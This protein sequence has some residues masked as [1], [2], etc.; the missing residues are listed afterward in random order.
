M[1]TDPLLTHPGFPAALAAAAARARAT[2]PDLTP[3]IERATALVLAGAVVLQEGTHAEVTTSTRPPE[4]YQ[5]NGDCSCQ[6]PESQT[7]GWC[8]HRLAV[9]LYRRARQVVEKQA[10]GS[11]EQEGEG[12]SAFPFPLPASCSPLLPEASAQVQVTIGGRQ[13]H[14]TLRDTDESRLLGRLEAL[15]ARYP[16][17]EASSLVQP[18]SGRGPEWCQKHAAPMKRHEQDG[19]VWYSHKVEGKYCRGK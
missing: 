15:L 11:T 14:V 17:A 8:T 4:R 2:L 19:D 7:D 10:V 6:T 5:V 12:H 16:Q 9:A 3:R 18:S 1:Q 13:V